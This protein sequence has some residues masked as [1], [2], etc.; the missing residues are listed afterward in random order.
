MNFGASKR[1]YS[2]VVVGLLLLSGCLPAA[3]KFDYSLSPDPQDWGPK[4]AQMEWW[5]LSSYLPEEQLSFHWAFFKVNAK[6]TPYFAGH[7]AVSDLKTGKVEFIENPYQTANFRFPPLYLEQGTVEQEREGKHWTLEQNTNSLN[8]TSSYTLNAGPLQLQLEPLK[9]PVVHPPGY[10]GTL[11]VGKMFYQ[12]ITRLGVSG[13]IG[14]RK[15]KGI[16]WMDHQWGDQIPGQGAIWDWMGLHLSN[17]NDLM[18]YRV[19]TLEGQLEGKVVQL[20]GSWV[21]AAGV[22]HAVQNL[23]MIPQRKYTSKT[24][25]DYLVDW[26]VKADTF[27]LELKAVQD[28]QELLSNTSG[29]AY[30]EGAMQGQGIW[31]G[32]PI[33]A[34]GMG[35]FV[36]PI[37]TGTLPKL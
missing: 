6:G 32:T 37:S 8:N 24:G 22:A 31:D 3:Q 4:P 33:E 13:K 29:V 10:S 2:A 36:S 18:L 11:E 34:H 30:W 9:K 27:S 28:N 5:Y 35:E 17:G 16:A 12:S 26:E 23:S 15:V 20:A 7:I 19:K 1:V 25:R 21:D 14:E